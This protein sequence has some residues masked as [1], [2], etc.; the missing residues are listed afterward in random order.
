MIWREKIIFFRQ[1]IVFFMHPNKDTLVYPLSGFQPISNEEKYKK[2]TAQEHVLKRFQAN[3]RY[4]L[5]RPPR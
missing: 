3:Y 5:I 1:S 4:W 2:V